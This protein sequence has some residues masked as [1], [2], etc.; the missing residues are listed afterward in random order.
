MH[1]ALWRAP[2]DCQ[3]AAH[4]PARLPSATCR[5][6]AAAA[7]PRYGARGNAPAIPWSTVSKNA[8]MSA[9][10]TQFTFFRQ[11]AVRERIQRVMLAAP[12]PESVREA[13]EVRL[14]DRVQ[15]LHHR[16][17]DDLVLQRRDAQWPLP[18]I[19]FGDVLS[20]GRLR[21]VRTPVHPCGRG[22]GD[23]LSRSSSY[24]SHVTP[25]TPGAASRFSSRNDQRSGRR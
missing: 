22:R 12:R 19:G 13:E 24:C 1:R 20:P 21:P 25:S 14:V 8:W 3:P 11:I 10:S 17:L 2:F 15:Y 16:P 23:W 9:S 18:P 5:S 6:G 7:C 4:L